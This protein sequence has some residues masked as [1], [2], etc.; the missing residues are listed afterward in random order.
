LLGLGMM[1]PP[2]GKIDP[3]ILTGVGELFGFATL[4]VVANAIRY[5]YDAKI[6]HGKT[7]VEIKD[8]E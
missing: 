3:S 8:T 2:R 4:G 7:S 5:G 6:T 1:L